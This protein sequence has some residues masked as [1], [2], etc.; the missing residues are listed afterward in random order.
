MLKRI[1][2]FTS[3]LQQNTPLREENDRLKLEQRKCEE[4]LARTSKQLLE[5]QREKDALQEI[6][7][8]ILTAVQES[9]AKKAELQEQLNVLQTTAGDKAL[10]ET[11]IAALKAFIKQTG[12][13]VERLQGE[14]KVNKGKLLQKDT[15]IY[16]RTVDLRTQ[17]E[18]SAAALVAA[19]TSAVREREE[20][21]RQLNAALA[22]VSSKAEENLSKSAEM[23]R[24][25][26][27]A[28]S[29]L[30]QVNLQ[31]EQLQA[32]LRT[33]EANILTATQEN[34]ASLEVART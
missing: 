24:Q 16:N 20:L 25:Q 34:T 29:N 32:Q 1:E 7:A 21:Q 11:L 5:A 19:T 15:E 13:E 8:G 6:Q 28:A 22:E 4:N 10:K 17:R 14:I 27:I 3:I 2:Q 26:E 12:E 23:V 18:A 33:A 9:E 31:K 30:Q